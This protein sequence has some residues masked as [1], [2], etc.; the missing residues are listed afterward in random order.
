MSDMLLPLDRPW[1]PPPMADPDGLVGIGGELLPSTLLQ[2]YMDGVFPWFNEGDPILWWSPDPRGVMDYD[3]FHIP[4]RLIRTI[5]SGRFTFTLDQCF[6]DV[7]RACGESRDEG[8]WITETMVAAYTRLHRMN[9][10]HSVEVWQDGELAGGVYGVAV[11][12][13]FSAESMFHRQTDASKAALV[14]LVS[15]L[16]RRGYDLID[17]QMANSH[18]H[19]FGARDIPRE[20]YLKRLRQAVPRQDVRFQ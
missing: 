7:M 16:Q 17:V 2:A 19:Q 15:H 12:G 11:G 20:E 5:R 9:A 4:Q 6:E 3:R 14:M 8:T 1:L 10:A 18:T 13:L